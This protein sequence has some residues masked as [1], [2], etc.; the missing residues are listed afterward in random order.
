MQMVGVAE[1]GHRQTYVLADWE[2]GAALIGTS[3]IR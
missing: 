2:G 3:L 1:M